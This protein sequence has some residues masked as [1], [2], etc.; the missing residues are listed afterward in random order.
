MSAKW[1]RLELRVHGVSEAAWH[2]AVKT[3]WLLCLR[4]TKQ[5]SMSQSKVPNIKGSLNSPSLHA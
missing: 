2:C 5:S 3:K 1:L 4:L